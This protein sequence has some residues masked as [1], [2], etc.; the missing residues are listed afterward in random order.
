M[1]AAAGNGFAALFAAAAACCDGACRC[2]LDEL[3]LLFLTA[4]PTRN[5]AAACPRYLLPS[6]DSTSRSSG[7]SN[8]HLTR[9]RRCI[10]LGFVHHKGAHVHLFMA[11]S[12]LSSC[13][14]LLCQHSSLQSL[15][16]GC[17]SVLD[18]CFRVFVPWLEAHV[19]NKEANF[20]P[21][22]GTPVFRHQTTCI[23][24]PSRNKVRMC[25]LC[26]NHTSIRNNREC[27]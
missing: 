15:L 16:L 5:A 18:K 9:L 25:E 13:C 11:A 4:A 19:V 22:K 20:G 1:T 27:S 10:W 26:G 6:L 14:C 17:L 7:L 3:R 8:W 12:E 24:G 2:G 21:I 23:C